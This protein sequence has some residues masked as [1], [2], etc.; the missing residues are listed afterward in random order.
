MPGHWSFNPVYQSPSLP[1][2]FEEF[3]HWGRKRAR[4]LPDMPASSSSSYAML[5]SKRLPTSEPDYFR[6]S[7]KS[8][9]AAAYVL[10]PI[11]IIEFFRF[12]VSPRTSSKAILTNLA[13]L[14]P[15]IQHMGPE[16]D[17][18]PV[19]KTLRTIV[20]LAADDNVTA[21]TNELQRYRTTVQGRSKLKSLLNRYQETGSPAELDLIKRLIPTRQRLKLTWEPHLYKSSALNQIIELGTNLRELEL[22]LCDSIASGV[23]AL[24]VSLRKLNY[25]HDLKLVTHPLN[26]HVLRKLNT[27]LVAS[28]TLE[29]LALSFEGD[30]SASLFT[31]LG[32]NRSLKSLRVDR[33]ILGE[34]AVSA[35][36]EMLCTH[37]GLEAL[38]LDD[39]KLGEYGP[40]LLLALISNTTLR[41]LALTRNKLDMFSLQLLASLLRHH[42]GSQLEDLNLSENNE[43]FTADNSLELMKTI[44][45]TNKLRSLNLSCNELG[46]DFA[47]LIASVIQPKSPHNFN[48]P[49]L[50]V[51]NLSYNPFGDHAG[52]DLLKALFYNNV[53]EELHLNRTLL[54]ARS[55]PVLLNLLTINRSLKHLSLSC[56]PA[57]FEHLEFCQALTLTLTSNPVLSS[58]NLASNHLTGEKFTALLPILLSLTNLSWLNLHNNGIDNSG[59]EELVKLL[60]QNKL[61]YLD[62]SDNDFNDE[63]MRLLADALRRNT[64]LRYLDIYN[65]DLGSEG[66]DLLLNALRDNRTLTSVIIDAASDQTQQEIEN[67]M[68]RNLHKQQGDTPFLSGV[69]FFDPKDRRNTTPAP[70]P[71]SSSLSSL[72]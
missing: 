23:S 48:H 20:K 25:L 64:S 37:Q 36:G 17:K 32:L 54:G 43:M 22:D 2:L 6:A 63:G 31:G 57:L 5:G 30:E 49:K 55:F 67:L 69:S 33:T 50:A 29:T 18:D 60:D 40:K 14:L 11:S 26:K 3:L 72:S 24:L 9:Q 45:N 56:N 1:E 53:V 59:I 66:E 61:V 13:A 7:K 4:Q 71:F 12:Y 70:L 65:A 28:R 16:Y 46:S 38:H 41:S 52:A 21:L 35:L 15:D 34:P 39:N 10:W 42:A 58:L 8:R 51:I 44:L 47:L 27:F 19:L 68:H 62:L